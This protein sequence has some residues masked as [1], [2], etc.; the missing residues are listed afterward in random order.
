MVEKYRHKMK[1]KMLCSHIKANVMELQLL[2]YIFSHPIAA[3]ASL[4]VMYDSFHYLINTSSPVS[5]PSS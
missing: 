4:C 3:R 2:I 5:S 1:C